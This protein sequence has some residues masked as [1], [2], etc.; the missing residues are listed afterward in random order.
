LVQINITRI[1]NAPVDVVFSTIAD[2]RQF[3]KAIPH[4][5]DFEILS[6]VKSGVG[7]RFCEVRLMRGK[8]AWTALEIT[9]YIQDE[10][11]RIVADS[12]GTVWD[13]VFSVK[14]ANG[15][16]EL[17]ITMSAK[18]HKFLPKMINPL[19]K[20]IIKKAIAKDMDFV[21]VFC[22]NPASIP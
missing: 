8:E 19:V 7:T 18:A 20:G 16:T 9:E 17:V 22:Q 4:I 1:I 15:K 5:V 2:I 3:S 12:H 14:A 6:D 13:T 11:V 21:K 10:R